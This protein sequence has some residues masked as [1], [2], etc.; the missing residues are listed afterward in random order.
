[1]E[2]NLKLF[3]QKHLLAK[4]K[5][6]PTIAI[7]TEDFISFSNSKKIFNVRVTAL[8]NNTDQLKSSKKSET[9]LD[10]HNFENVV[11]WI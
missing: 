6:N 8:L 7:T 4:I 1:M 11:G 2:I 3:F 9:Y 5:G 10:L